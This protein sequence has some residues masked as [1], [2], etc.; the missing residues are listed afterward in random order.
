INA[1]YDAELAAL[2]NQTASEQKQQAQETQ[3]ESQSAE[4]QKVGIEQSPEIQEKETPLNTDLFP[5]QSIEELNITYARKK[6]EQ[7]IEEL[8]ED[9]LSFIENI[10]DAK[11][12]LQNIILERLVKYTGKDIGS[13]TDKRS[14]KAIDRIINKIKQEFFNLMEQERTIVEVESVPDSDITNV[15]VL[16]IEGI[17]EQVHQNTATLVESTEK[18]LANSKKN[19]NIVATE[20]AILNVLKEIKNFKC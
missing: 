8:P 9:L 4:Q 1:K 12:Y 19:S 20:E 15:D 11:L 10:E 2:N 18:I 3:E 14:T 6:A 17:I 16:S 5:T 7:I 13:I